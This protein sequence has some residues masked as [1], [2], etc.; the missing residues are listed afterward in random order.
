SSQTF[1][2]TLRSPFLTTTLLDHSCAAPTTCI[3]YLSSLAATLNSTCA[4]DLAA[5]NPT[6]TMALTGLLGYASLRTATCLKSATGSYCFADAITNSTSDEDAYVYYL[7]VGHSLP[8]TTKMTCNKCL[9]DVVGVFGAAAANRT[10][11][12]AA[13]YAQGAGVVNGVCGKGWVNETMPSA[14]TGGAAG[15]GFGGILGVVVALVMAVVLV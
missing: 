11:P 15:G 5:A 9:R 4:P 13:V 7:G 6:A 14:L 3:P 10:A 8:T 1:F 12:V 2:Q